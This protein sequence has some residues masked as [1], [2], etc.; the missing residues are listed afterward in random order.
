MPA[1][2]AFPRGGTVS[3]AYEENEGNLGCMNRVLTFIGTRPEIIKMS[4]LFP[5][6]DEIF[7]H[8]IVH[9]GQHYSSNLDIC[10]FDELG[11]RAPDFNLEVGSASAGTQL[12]RVI[13]SLGSLLDSIQPEVVVVQGDTNT[14]LGGALAANKAF[15]SRMKLVHIEAGARSFLN[16]QP[17]ELNRKLIDQMSDLLF[18]PYENDKDNLLREGIDER[19]IHV[20]G[21]T[22]VDS[23][24]RTAGLLN[25][26]S[27]AHQFG[28][29]TGEFAVA[30]FHRQENVDSQEA[31]LGIV[32]ALNEISGSIPVIV[33][34]HPRTRKMMEKYGI[35]FESTSVWGIGPIGYRDLISLIVGCRFCVTDSGGIQEECG[36]LGKPAVI[37]REKTEHVRYIESKLHVLTGNEPSRIIEESRELLK[38]EVLSKRRDIKQDFEPQTSVR[39]TA[40]MVEWLKQK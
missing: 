39:I 29:G 33:P 40:V 31:L 7:D 26:Y 22:V 35:R 34:L 28:L 32:N 3:G 18:A 19:R 6:F 14:S 24:R 25:G 12:S 13:V 37:L 38:D 9:S 10:F 36:V 4:P 21:N 2:Y 30:T 27:F 20:V 11:L 23:C 8:T 15:D 1:R 5:R 16:N 17:E